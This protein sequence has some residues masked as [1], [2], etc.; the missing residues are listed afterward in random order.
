MVLH[1][2]EK[3]DFIVENGMVLSSDRSKLIECL[4]DGTAATLYVIPDGVRE[5]SAYAFSGRFL[6]ERVVI[7]ESV[8]LIGPYAFNRC[9]NLARTY[10]LSEVPP[11][12]A[13]NA[14]DD[15]D[16]SLRSLYV[17]KG[18]LLKYATADGW[19]KY[20]KDINEFDKTDD[21]TETEILTDVEVEAPCAIYDLQGHIVGWGNNVRHLSPG[22]YVVDGKKM[23]VR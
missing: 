5:V 7:P 9:F 6:Y 1:P 23:V 13:P 20:G 16:L 17:P 12:I 11:V 22:I 14:I 10:V 3:S 21:I 8:E 4:P 2:G 15:L 19:K 18:N